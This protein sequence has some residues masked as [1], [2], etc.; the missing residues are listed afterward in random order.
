MKKIY[1]IIDSELIIRKSST[2]ISFRQEYGEVGLSDNTFTEG[3]ET[4][5]I[6]AFGIETI[7]YVTV[8]GVNLIEN[9]HYTQVGAN[10]ISI[11]KGGAALK[12]NPSITTTILVAYVDDGTCQDIQIGTSPAITTFL[13]DKYIGK[14]E[15]VT[16]DFS[17]EENDGRNIYWSILVDGSSVPIYSGSALNSTNGTYVNDNG[18]ITALTYTVSSE[19]YLNNVGTYLPFTLVVVYDLTDDGTKMDEKVMSSVEYYMGGNSLIGDVSVSPTAIT[20]TENILIT[21]DYGIVQNDFTPDVFSWELAKTVAGG[22]L[23]T[24]RTGNQDSED[25]T[26]TFNEN[27]QAI[28][29]DFY[30]QKYH[31]LIQ[32]PEDVVQTELDN[33][34]VVVSVAIAALRAN[35]GYLDAAIMSYEPAP[36]QPWVKIGSDPDN[37]VNV[38]QYNN[39]IPRDIFQTNYILSNVDEEVYTGAE[40]NTFGDTVDF[41]YFVIEVPSTW[42]DIVFD[43][44][45]G[46]INAT[47]FN[48]ITG[49]GAGGFFTAYLYNVAPSQVTNPADYFLNSVI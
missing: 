45:S 6:T 36:A 14:D 17:I 25:V 39:R 13:L 15:T 8:N 26:G 46:P 23:I 9:K 16:F 47:A 1:N 30:T 2:N 12:A 32:E 11:S 7:L 28:P 44:G 4:S 43:G 42:P 19:Y 40:V 27:I 29:G 34:S 35:V 20:N 37:A 21:V 31:L 10:K 41:V 24:L 38:L 22:P 3:N 5:F 48:V 33:A 18:D 49:V